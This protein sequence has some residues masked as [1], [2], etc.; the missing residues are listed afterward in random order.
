MTG[1]GRKLPRAVATLAAA[2]AAGWWCRRRLFSLLLSC[3]L[4]FSSQP[5]SPL[6]FFRCLLF[7]S[8]IPS[9]LSVAVG[10]SSVSGG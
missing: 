10:D 5:P 2:D 7:F 3:L 6:P 9:W 8:S 4:C 1:E